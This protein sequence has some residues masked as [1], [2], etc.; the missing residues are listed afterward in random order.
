MVD[1]IVFKVLDNRYAV[2]IDN[3]QR[4]I[5]C[6]EL[7]N[8]PNAHPFVDG[9]MSYEDGVLKVLSFRKLIGVVSYYTELESL[10]AKLK[11]A[12][13]A[14]VNALGESLS[15][16]C[17]FTKTTNPHMCELGRWIDAFTSYDDRVTEVFNNLVEQHKQLHL[18]G[19]DALEVYKTDK[20]EAKRI[21]D[22]DIQNIYKKTMGALDMFT[23][24]LEGVSNSLQ[25]LLIYE[26]N[27]KV[28]AIKVDSIE[29]IAHVEES[30]IMA[31]NEEEDSSQFLELEGVLD[32]D[33]VLINVIK[34]VSIP[35]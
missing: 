13:S 10:F 31:S 21:F 26:S 27:E 11:L 34:K 14:W 28:F 29:D 12:H 19:G 24:E 2:R 16:G 7:T 3:I 20:K 1:F 35:S 15:T 32:M 23:Q 30:Q 33:G 18:R 4:I 25:K 5:P 9:M 8:I 22:V 6:N 17:E